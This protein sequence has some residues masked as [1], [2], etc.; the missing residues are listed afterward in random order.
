MATALW[1]K[2]QRVNVWTCMPSRAPVPSHGSQKPGIHRSRLHVV[3]LSTR[4]RAAIKLS[5]A[6]AEA[7]IRLQ[8]NKDFQL[9]TEALNAYRH[10]SIEFC[11]YGPGEMAETN[12][13]MAR[14]ITEVMRGIGKAPDIINRT[15]GRGH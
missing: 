10:E 15:R 7:V 13:G 5:A 8:N 4:R 6:Q 12:R 3:A 9:F 14:A 1:R 11:L 2:P